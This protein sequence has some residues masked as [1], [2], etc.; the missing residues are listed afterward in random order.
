M[1]PAPQAARTKVHDQ[2]NRFAS[3]WSIKRRLL[4]LTW[5]FARALLF[6]P[7]PKYLFQWRNWLL[8]AFGARIGH[9]VFISQSAVIRMPWHL[10][11]RS[12]ACVGEHA[13]IYNL[14]PVTIGARSTVAQHAYLCAG[15]HDFSRP[16][17]PL[18]TAPI[19]IGDDVFVGARAMILLGVSVGDA[20][21]VGAGAVV[22]KDVPPRVVVIGNP[23]RLL[24]TRDAESTGTGLTVC[25]EIPQRAVETDERT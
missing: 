9:N 16:D 3:P 11:V 14:G 23:A 2:A 25:D 7:S 19:S 1:T 8:R 4:Y 18:I 10:V 6:R 15:S 17:V 5:S 20:T 24:R 12:D 13:E 22:A 21:I